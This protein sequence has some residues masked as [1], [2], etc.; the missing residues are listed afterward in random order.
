[1]NR[2]SIKI[3]YR[4]CRLNVAKFSIISEIGGIDENI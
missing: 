1:M 3:R 2:K 4:G